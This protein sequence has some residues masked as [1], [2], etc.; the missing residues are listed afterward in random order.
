VGQLLGI[1][2]VGAQLHR[3]PGGL[4]DL[5]FGEVDLGVAA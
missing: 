3:D 2:N 1:T 4:F 5:Q